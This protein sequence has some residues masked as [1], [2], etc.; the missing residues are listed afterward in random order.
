MPHTHLR[1]Y[2]R[3]LLAGTALALLGAL[4]A[5]GGWAAAQPDWESFLLQGAR[6]IRFQSLGPG[7]QSMTFQYAGPVTTQSARLRTAMQRAGW[8]TDLDQLDCGGP[9]LLGGVVFVFQRQSL[10]NIVSEVATVEQQGPGPYD[11]RVVL[12]RCLR[13]PRIACWPSG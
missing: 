10:F 7:M 3:A 4:C 1:R 2:K 13:L 8:Q 11:V 6:D 9:C 5:W 12:R